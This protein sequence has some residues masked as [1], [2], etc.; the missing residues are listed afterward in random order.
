MLETRAIRRLLDG[1]LVFGALTAR[2][3][4]ATSVPTH[5]QY[6]GLNLRGD[7]GLKIREPVRAWYYFALPLTIGPITRIYDCRAGT[8]RPSTT[9]WASAYSLQWWRSPPRGRSSE[10]PTDSRSLQHL[11]ATA[12]ASPVELLR[13]IS[14]MAR[15]I[16][17]TDIQPHATRNVNRPVAAPLTA[18]PRA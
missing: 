11:R 4:V 13:R 7:T 6:L 14:V 16:R 1:T 18:G 2:L 10:P 8:Q 15:R 5:A 9:A 12:K 17:E 3:L